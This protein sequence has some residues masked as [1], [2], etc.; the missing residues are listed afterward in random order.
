[1]EHM[2]LVQILPIFYRRGPSLWCSYLHGHNLIDKKW[3]S[4]SRPKSEGGKLKKQIP[5]S[6]DR[7]DYTMMFRNGLDGKITSPE[8]RNFRRRT[9]PLD[10]DSRTMTLAVSRLLHT[11]SI[12]VHST[13][14]V[15]CRQS[16]S[17][18]AQITSLI[19][20]GKNHQ[21]CCFRITSVHNSILYLN[22]FPS[23]KP[24][25]SWRAGWLILSIT[26]FSP[27]C[28]AH[29][30]TLKTPSTVW[31]EFCRAFYLFTM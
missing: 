22:D 30:L 1:M 12:H 5:V 17:Y 26:H 14:E 31:S 6:L 28:F 29:S 7:K 13:Q 25:F 21:L 24:F 11:R 4:I 3:N 19:K 27:F 15:Y 9:K 23:D 20:T 18:A 8:R 16:A 10:L 2:R